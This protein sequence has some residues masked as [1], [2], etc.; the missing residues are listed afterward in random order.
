MNPKEFVVWALAR[1][2]SDTCDDCEIKDRCFGRDVYLCDHIVW[3]LD[4]LG[5]NVN[6]G[7]RD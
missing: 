1:S 7:S 2:V 6:D 4:Y 3:V 5:V